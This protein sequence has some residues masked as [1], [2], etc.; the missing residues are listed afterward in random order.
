M[1][2]D[3]EYFEL[4]SI[5]SGLKTAQSQFL[6]ACIVAGCNYLQNVHGIGI[7]KAFEFVKSGYVF[8]EL[9]RKGASDNYESMFRMA[10][11]VFK[12][13]SVFNLT[14]LLV[15]SLEDLTEDPDTDLQIIVDSILQIMILKIMFYVLN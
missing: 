4:P 8:E 15:Q 11:S 1:S 9:K 6:H 10:L 7:N 5:L 12:H 2:G 14:I 3:G 13:Q